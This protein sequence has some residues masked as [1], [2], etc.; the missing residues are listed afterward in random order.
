VYRQGGR[1]RPSDTRPARPD[2]SEPGPLSVARL[3]DSATLALPDTTEFTMR[4]Y[5]V[6]FTPD[7]VSRPTVGY[8]RDNFG[9]GF[10]G[11]TAIQLSDILG[12]QLIVVSAA[13]NGRLSEAQVFGAYANLSR[14]INWA[15]GLSQDPLFYYDA[16]QNALIGPNTGMFTQRLRRLVVRQVFGEAYYP[17]NRFKRIEFGARLVNIG[18]ATLNLVAL[19]DPA[20]GQLLAPPYDS[21]SNEGS[22]TFVQPTLALVHDNSL[23]GWTSPFFGKRYRFE[24]AP[25]LGGWRFTQLLGD[26]RRYDMLKFPFTISTRV[27]GLARVG[28]D[29][30]QFPIFIGTPDLVRGYTFG[31]FQRSGECSVPSPNTRTG[32]PEVDQ[33]IGSRVIVANAEF[34]FPLV[35]NLTLGFLPVGFPP[36]EGALFYDAGIAFNGSSDLRLSRPEGADLVVVRAPVTSYGVG[37]RANLFGFAIIRLDYA[38]PRQR[39]G[40]GGY[41]MV[42]LGPPF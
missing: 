41:W 42:S 17:V 32:C 24:V 38:V 23:F 11:G 7:F 4:P 33:L 12:N 9:R 25:S 5:R 14:R 3:L 6:R 22:I 29:G 15:V 31:S 34:R 35:R 20:N 19:Y 21:V 30:E 16:S 2:S 10:F 13:V 28:R 37:L 1:L 27:F 39:P 8:A 18:L 36:I 40:H 26:Y